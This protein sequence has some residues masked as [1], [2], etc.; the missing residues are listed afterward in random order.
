MY[1]KNIKYEKLFL[2]RVEVFSTT[3]LSVNHIG[4]SLITGRLSWRS[5]P[6]VTSILELFE[7]IFR[8]LS[9]PHRSIPF[10]CLLPEDCV[11][12]SSL[13]LQNNL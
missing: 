13:T 11:A 5:S 6:I 12:D 2:T 4:R 3:V 9:G 7:S 10:V 8:I 1:F